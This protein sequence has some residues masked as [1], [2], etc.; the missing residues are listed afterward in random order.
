MAGSVN[1]LSLPSRLTI[2]CDG[3]SYADAMRFLSKV[4]I[5]EDDECWIWL[6]ADKGNGYGHV[7]FRR[8][9]YPAHRLAFKMFVGEIGRDLDVCHKCDTRKCVNPNHL[10]A[11][12]R[13][14]NMAD[15][16]NKGR[17]AK[18]AALPQTKLLSD[19]LKIVM[20]M[21]AAGVKYAEIAR[22]FGVTR[23]LIGKIAIKNGVRRYAK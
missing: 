20:D 5:G 19:D 21:T 3:Y 17:Q 4:R 12:T 10:F 16:V 15:A 2:N 6:G 23:Q 1:H 9:Q 18:G 8:K 7:S 14:E 11:G 13:K 22:N